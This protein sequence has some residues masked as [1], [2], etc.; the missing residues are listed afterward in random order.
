[1]SFLRRS[2][3]KRHRTSKSHR[4]KKPNEQKRIYILLQPVRYAEIDSQGLVFNA[5]YLTYFDT[6]LTE[7]MREVDFDY[8]AMVSEEN[9]DFHL[10]KSTVEYRGPIGFDDV[11]D[12]GVTVKK[13]GNPA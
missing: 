2:P 11:I 8:Q 7:Y 13:I 3:C 10:V 6:A 5:H 1:M 9:I 12:I 4:D